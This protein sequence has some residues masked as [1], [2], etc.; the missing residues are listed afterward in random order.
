MDPQADAAA[1][2][3]VC[4]SLQR[5]LRGFAKLDEFALASS[6]SFR[7]EVLGNPPGAENICTKVFGA[8]FVLRCNSRPLRWTRH[9]LPVRW[10]LHFRPLRC[11][12]LWIFTRL[13]NVDLNVK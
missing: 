4:S 6:E 2:S 5:S 10:A 7:A 3:G 12:D 1:I 8:K 11:D 9:S 13:S